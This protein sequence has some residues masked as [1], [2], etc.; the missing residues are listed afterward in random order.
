MDFGVW[1]LP[2]HFIFQPTTKPNMKKKFYVGCYFDFAGECSNWCLHQ[3]TLGFN[4]GDNYN[5]AT[6]TQTEAYFKNLTP[7]TVW[8][9]WP[10]GKTEEGRNQY[11]LIVDVTDQSR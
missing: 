4:I 8:S 7:V 11:M 10:W 1:E 9:W 2:N 6:F 5:L 3:R